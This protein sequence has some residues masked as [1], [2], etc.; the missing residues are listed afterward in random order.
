MVDVSIFSPMSSVCLAADDGEDLGGE[1][2]DGAG[3][4]GEGEAT[5]ADLGEEAVVAEEFVFPQDL[6]DDLLGTAGE[7]GTAWAGPG[8]ERARGGGAG[9]VRRACCVPM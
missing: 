3:G 9:R 2:L 1:Q 4:V 7:Q 6:V 8:V 5:E